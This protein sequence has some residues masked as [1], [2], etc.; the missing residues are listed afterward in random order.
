[1]GTILEA[2][3]VKVIKTDTYTLVISKEDKRMVVESRV[4][5]KGFV[6][7]FISA[8]SFRFGG[9][10]P[11]AHFYFDNESMKVTKRES[12]KSTFNRDFE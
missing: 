5:Y 11:C 2:Y 9:R 7:K 12:F 1:L 6:Q 4:V 10:F 3:S 8:L